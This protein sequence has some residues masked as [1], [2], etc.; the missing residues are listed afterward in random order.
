MTLRLMPFVFMRHGETLLNRKRVMGGRTDVPLTAVGEAQARAAAPLLAQQP[1]SCVAV[2]PLIRARQTATLALP[3]APQHIVP[4]LRERDWGDLEERPLAEQPPYEET[5]PNG[6]PWAAFY[7]RV[8]DAL[9]A[10]LD[11]HER[12]LVI[13]HSG[14]FRVIRQLATGSPYGPRINNAHPM[15]IVPSALRHRWTILPLESCE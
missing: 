7:S 9:N 5:P 13:A 11:Q 15:L 14:I 1:W 6:E 3:D 8:T 4:D 10:L 12:P 2:S